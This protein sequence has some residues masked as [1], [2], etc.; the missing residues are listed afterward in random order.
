L[1]RP[2]D[3]HDFSTQETTANHVLQVKTRPHKRGKA[4]SKAQR[5]AQ[6]LAAGAG[7]SS[8]DA[9]FDLLDRAVSETDTTSQRKHPTATHGYS[10]LTAADAREMLAT[11][12]DLRAVILPSAHPLDF[13]VSLHDWLPDVLRALTGMGP[14]VTWICSRHGLRIRPLSDH[15]AMDFIIPS[16]DFVHWRCHSEVR[17]HLDMDT[18]ETALE[19][20]R[21][22]YT[23]MRFGAGLGN[24]V[25]Y[26]DPA[27]D[28]STAALLRR[29]VADDVKWPTMDAVGVDIA[30]PTAWLLDLAT[31]AGDDTKLVSFVSD[32]QHISFRTDDFEVCRCSVG[33][34]PTLF[35]DLQV[36][37]LAPLCLSFTAALIVQSID[38]ELVSDRLELAM[39][40][41]RPL[42]ITSPLRRARCSMWQFF[43]APVVDPTDPDAERL[44]SKT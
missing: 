27:L 39:Q 38:P 23:T 13:T 3:D 44:C 14:V 16:C 35:G 31:R 2:D 20:L 28:A 36:Q 32:G 25:L 17:L 26:L 19:G 8:H 42:Q 21:C 5:A 7:E 37:A 29:S 33:S 40:H 41:G 43:L 4:R 18:L 10:Y 30:L 34:T 12:R 11:S 1:R 15:G 22:H 6:V 24:Q 9:A